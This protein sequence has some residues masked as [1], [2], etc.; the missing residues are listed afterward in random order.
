MPAVWDYLGVCFSGANLPAT[1]LLL[2]AITYWLLAIVSGLDL[3]FLDFDLNVDG[4]ADLG[5]IVGVGVVALRFLNIGLVP[6]AI[7]GSI[8]AINWWM[9]SMLL[10]RLLD[11]VYHPELRESWSHA[12]Q[13]TIRNF[14][15]AL[16]L[17]K[18]FTQPLR[19]KFDAEEPNA[20]AD[21]IGQT[22]RIV[23]SEV[24]ERFGQAEYATEGA[25][26]KLN[27]RT[28]DAAE[29]T[30]GD[31]AVI[32]DFDPEQNVYFVERMKTEV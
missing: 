21:L 7:W 16:V 23:T 18:L 13:W 17:T 15:I 25:P 19:G 12:I 11:N 3:D 6:L 8:L 26:L 2:L 20:A 10:D 1:V 14:A 4:E 28:R 24:N 30:K 27:V 22:C 29:L 31:A 5:E 9:V 32:V